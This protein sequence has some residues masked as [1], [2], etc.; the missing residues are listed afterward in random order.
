LVIWGIFSI[1][2]NQLNIMSKKKYN[3]TKE[4]V[5]GRLLQSCLSAS[6]RPKKVNK[7]INHSDVTFELLYQMMETQNWSC[8]ET[9]IPFLLLD[10]RLKINETTELGMNR[11]Y[12][13]SIDRINNNKGYTIDNIRIVTL[14]Y[15]NLKNIYDDSEVWEWINLAKQTI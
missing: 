3:T 11:L 13:P 15:N 7:G 8:A 9:N 5:V 6:R 1:F 14:G 2:G 4:S 10:D 12:L